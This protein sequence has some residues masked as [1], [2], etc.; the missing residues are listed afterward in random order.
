MKSLRHKKST[1]RLLYIL[2]P[3]SFLSLLLS[4]CLVFFSANSAAGITIEEITGAR[5]EWGITS[6]PDGN[7]WV[8]L[9]DEIGRV[10]TAGIM[11]TFK[12]PTSQSMIRAIT[13]GPDG[14]LWFTEFMGNK[15]GRITPQGVI[16]EFPVPTAFSLPNDI[17][18]G[19]DGNLWFTE[20][21]ANKVGRITPQGYITE[22]SLP[23]G[24]SRPGGITSGPDGNLWF[25]ISSPGKIGRITPTGIITEFPVSD[26]SDFPGSITSGPD[27][28]LWFIGQLG[29]IGR[30]TPGGISTEFTLPV[31][32]NPPGFYI[33]RQLG[34]IT[35]GPD[36]NFWFT[37][38]IVILAVGLGTGPAGVEH[39]SWIGRITP[40]GVITEFKVPTNF[41]QPL[42]I[43][44][45]PDGNIWFTEATRNA[46]GKVTLNSPPQPIPTMNEWGMVIFMI[47]AGLGSFYYLKRKTS[48]N[49]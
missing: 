4:F 41:S 7:L 47:L 12:T 44:V 45:G 26:A 23:S 35:A 5:G 6:G 36:G 43:T 24:S 16:T 8:G 19:P 10:T 30:I 1:Q 42:G 20:F 17:T 46:L 9:Y 27:R 38:Q 14:N 29:R 21:W 39:T 18:A 48:L 13:K 49:F 40:A 3:V 34:A 32:P 15:I 25:T 28:N 2:E 33:Y 37:E 22:F 31:I 11:T